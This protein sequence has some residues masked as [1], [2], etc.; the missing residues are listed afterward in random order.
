MY[1][2]WCEILNL[3]FKTDIAVGQKVNLIL[4]LELEAQGNSGYRSLLMSVNIILNVITWEL[5]VKL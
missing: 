2:S 1:V 3:T 5:A 4:A